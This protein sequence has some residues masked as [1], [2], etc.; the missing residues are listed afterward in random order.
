MSFV[1]RLL[2]ERGQA[3]HFGE[4]N[5]L[6]LNVCDVVRSSGAL[7]TKETVFEVLEAVAQERFPPTDYFLRFSR[8][9]ESLRRAVIIQLAEIMDV[10]NLDTDLPWALQAE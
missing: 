2:S 10:L 1:A 3:P 7:V 9:P 8:Q 4:V 5:S 6:A